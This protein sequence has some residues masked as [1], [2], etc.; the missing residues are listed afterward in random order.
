MSYESRMYRESNLRDRWRELIKDLEYL[1]DLK[2]ALNDNLTSTEST[3]EGKEY[4]QYNSDQ[5]DLDC[6]DDTCIRMR[7]KLFGNGRRR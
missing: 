4:E 6:D 1:V 5:D 7:Q 2:R 3:D